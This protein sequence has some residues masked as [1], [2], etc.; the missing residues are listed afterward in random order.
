VPARL[1]RSAHRLTLHLPELW[2]GQPA[3]Q[4]L[5]AA[6]HNDHQNPIDGSGLNGLQ[7]SVSIHIRAVAV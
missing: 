5:H 6:V 7:L 4:T 2:P 3:W 1:A